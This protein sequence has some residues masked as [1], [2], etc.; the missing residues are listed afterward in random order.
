M[1]ALAVTALSTAL[2]GNSS[3]DRGPGTAPRTRAETR[4]QNVN[5]NQVLVKAGERG[6]G[7]WVAREMMA[8]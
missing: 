8:S 3:S 2:H 6:S 4:A 7:A 1:I 5:A